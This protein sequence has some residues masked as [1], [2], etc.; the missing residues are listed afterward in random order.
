MVHP[1]ISNNDWRLDQLKYSITTMQREGV[2]SFEDKQGLKALEAV[3]SFFEIDGDLWYYD[4]EIDLKTNKITKFLRRAITFPELVFGKIK[5]YK[6]IILMSGTLFPPK[7]YMTLYGLTNKYALIEVPREAQKVFYATYVQTNMNSR[8]KNRNIG[9][10]KA[11]LD[12]IIQLHSLN[13]QHTLVFSTS[14]NYTTNMVKLAN[15]YYPDQALYAEGT[16]SQNQVLI[17]KFRMLDHELLFVTMSGSFSEGIEIKE[18]KNGASKITLIIFT[19]IPHPPPTLTHRLL[20]Y[21]YIQRFGQRQTLLFLKWLPIYQTLLQA[22]GR[23]IRRP[24]DAC[25]IICLD[26]RLPALQIFPQKLMLTTSD[27]QR[28]I[29]QLKQFYEQNIN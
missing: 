18:E 20:E 21:K 26:Y 27:F 14:H 19:G 4:R 16:S 1:L 5:K 12:L 25:A 10:L 7:A 11:Q 22:A 17:D 28:I 15:Y 8:M 23:G 6:R 2:F 24:T 9:M 13:P 29:E 3:N